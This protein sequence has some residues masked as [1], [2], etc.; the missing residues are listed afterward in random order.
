M[1]KVFVVLLS[2]L[3]FIVAVAYI[4]LTQVK[5]VNLRA[6]VK[7]LQ[8]EDQ[9]VRN[10]ELQTEITNI[11]QTY[12]KAIVVYEAMDDLESSG[13]DINSLKKQFA[14]TLSLLS[15]RQYQEA[16][17]TLAD[18]RS[19]MDAII[20]GQAEAEKKKIIAPPPVPKPAPAAKTQPA[21][22][23]A[24]APATNNAPPGSGYSQQIVAANGQTFVVSVV[25]ADLASTRVIVDTASTA[26]CHQDCPVLSLSEYVAR[27]GAFAGVNGSY[28]CPAT[29]PTCTDKKNVFEIMAMNKDKTYFNSDVDPN[30]DYPAVIFRN[31]SIQFISAIANWNKSTDIDSMLA[32]YPL[33]VANK[34]NIYAGS[35]VDKLNSKGNRSFVANIGSTVYIGVVRSASVGDSAAVMQTLGME[36]ALNLDDGGST[37]LWADGG[38]KVGPGRGLPNVILFISK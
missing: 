12:N 35:G 37:A 34:Q 11:A 36:N 32:N 38:Y 15:Q 9:F 23:P 24:P 28:F 4:W 10:E 3:V 5:Q 14:T 1:K 6:Q 20:T 30:T 2:L 16:E 29:Y 25:A 19:K 21:P 22:A 7:S 26:D 33:L 17:A 13:V 18:I 27:N 8:S 31:G